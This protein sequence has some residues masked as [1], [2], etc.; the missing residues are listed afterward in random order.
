M[1]EFY[2]TFIKGLTPILL[3]L[4]QKNRRGRNT[5]KHIPWD[6]N[7]PDTKTRQ[8]YKKKRRK[9]HATITDSVSL[10]YTDEQYMQKSLRKYQ[11]TKSNKS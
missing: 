1:G 3:K 10:S 7:H 11:Q 8:S 4:F 6:H 2:Q 5:S 9:L